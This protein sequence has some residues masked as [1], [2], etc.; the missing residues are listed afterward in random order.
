MKSYFYMLCLMQ[1]PCCCSFSTHGTCKKTGPNCNVHLMQLRR[2]GFC[3]VHTGSCTAVKSA[4]IHTVSQN[5]NPSIYCLF[6]VLF[7]CAPLSPR[8]H[9]DLLLFCSELWF[10]QAGCEWSVVGFTN[11]NTTA[12]NY[13]RNQSNLIKKSGDDEIWQKYRD[14]DKM[15]GGNSGARIRT[16]VYSPGGEKLYWKCRLKM[17]RWRWR[18]VDE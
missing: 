4:F 18:C 13:G 12:I 11:K 17:T 15:R 14:E 8:T 16:V 7:V 10:N 3:G 1:Y 9:S 5:N 6:F 2:T